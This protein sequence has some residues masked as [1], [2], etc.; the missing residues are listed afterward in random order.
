MSDVNI[1]ANT[2]DIADTTEIDT[3]TIQV[4]VKDETD[5]KNQQR[6]IINLSV[7]YTVFDL[8]CLI[9]QKVRYKLGTFTLVW[10]KQ[11]NLVET[12]TVF[13]ITRISIH[14]NQFPTID[15]QLVLLQLMRTN[16]DLPFVFV[17]TRF[18]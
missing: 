1:T 10:D 18:H 3:A 17:L 9:G 12:N 15:I 8:H 5:L 13:Q 6:Q 11:W 14:T 16:F 2:E 7:S 4:I